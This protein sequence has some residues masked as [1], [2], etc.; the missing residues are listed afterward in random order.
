MNCWHFD[1]MK[2]WKN[3][4]HATLSHAS[5]TELLCRNM[6]HHSYIK[7]TEEYKVYFSAFKGALGDRDIIK[8]TLLLVKWKTLFCKELT[9]KKCSAPQQM[10]LPLITVSFYNAIYYCEHIQHYS[11]CSCLLREGRS[12]Y[13]IKWESLEESKI[14]QRN[15]LR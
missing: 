12:S 6:M 1:Q 10:L 13:V 15:S 4:L 14:T 5:L 11:I 9:M 3:G 2:T 7:D 8:T